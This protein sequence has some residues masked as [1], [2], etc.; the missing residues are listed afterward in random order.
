MWRTSLRSIAPRHSCS[1]RCSRRRFRRGSSRPPVRCRPRFKPHAI[2]W[3]PARFHRP[4]LAT[5]MA[6]EG[7]TTTARMRRTASILRKSTR[8][9]RAK[10]GLTA[11]LHAARQ[12]HIE[13]ARA[14]LDGGA[15]IDQPGA[16]DATTPLLMAVINGE[17]DMAMFLI[18]ARRRIR[19]SASN[20]NG[21]DAAVGRHQHAVAAAD[22]IPAAAGDGAAE[23]D[24]SRRHEGAARQGR[25]RRTRR[26]AGRTPGISCTA[27][28]VTATAGL[29]IPPAPPRSG[30][31]PMRRISM[32]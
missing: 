23:G 8:R 18:G 6:G 26:D 17:F 27:A 22:A 5:R 9:S 28:A 29:R 3:P 25:R 32:R 11:L 2:C 4:S 10:G 12:G 20:S 14:L 15:P 30:A 19:I 21:V 24:V 1:A 13:A 31:Q 16:G 7:T